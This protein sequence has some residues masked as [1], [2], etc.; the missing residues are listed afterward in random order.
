MWKCENACPDKMKTVV[1]YARAYL[2]VG[3]EMMNVMM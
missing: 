1:N 3:P 2:C